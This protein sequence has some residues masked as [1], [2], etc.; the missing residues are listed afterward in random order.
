VHTDE[1]L[2]AGR[3]GGRDFE[4]LEVLRET[5]RPLWLT[6]TAP[7]S[8]GAM[9]DRSLRSAMNQE[10][11]SAAFLGSLPLRPFGPFLRSVGR[12]L[13]ADRTPN[14]ICAA[15]HG[16]LAAASDGCV[17][18]PRGLCPKVALACL[19][20]AFVFEVRSLGSRPGSTACPPGLP[21]R[22]S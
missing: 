13:E 11:A 3:A 20:H 6:V 17:E 5:G 9:S 21:S 16:Q 14:S 1:N 15:M 10:M 12:S 7:G 2:L 22:R 18:I 8:D 19:E 4:M